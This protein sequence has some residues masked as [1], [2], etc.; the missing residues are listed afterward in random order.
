MNRLKQ[1][2]ELQTL[3]PWQ[4]DEI[5]SDQIEGNL[6][7]LRIKMIPVAQGKTKEGA[8]KEL[9]A[10][11]GGLGSVQMYDILWDGRRDGIGG[12]TK[13]FSSNHIQEAIKKYNSL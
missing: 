10:N 11:L 13:S 1:Y 6:G 5:S 4:V 2:S 9:R 8:D 3:P 7:Q 12:F